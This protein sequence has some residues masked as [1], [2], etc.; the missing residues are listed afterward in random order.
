[1]INEQLHGQRW[2]PLLPSQHNPVFELFF[3]PGYGGS[4]F[5]PPLPLTEAPSSPPPS[6]PE[7]ALL[8]Q[9]LPLQQL[10]SILKAM[11]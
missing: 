5:Q 9:S 8:L 6:G 11:A 4:V 3:L 1:M 7:S 2:V 10:R